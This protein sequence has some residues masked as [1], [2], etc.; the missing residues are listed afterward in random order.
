[1]NDLTTLSN[2]R[3]TILLAEIAA[4]LH[5]IGKLDPNFLFKQITDGD[6][7]NSELKQHNLYIDNYHYRRFASPN[8]KLFQNELYRK[9]TEKK[10]ATTPEIADTLS[11]LLDDQTINFCKKA[12]RFIN[13]FYY[14]NGPLYKVDTKE[15]LT[16]QAK[17]EE[18]FSKIIIGKNL[19]PW[20]L[21]DLL[22]LFWD[23]F[24]DQSSADG[25]DRTFALSPLMHPSQAANLPALLILSHTE[26]VIPEKKEGTILIKTS[27]KDLCYSSAFGYDHEKI[28]VFALQDARY[29]LIEN[30]LKVCEDPIGKRTELLDLASNN[31]SLGLGDTQWPI[32]EINLWDFSSSI[33]ALFKSGV[34]RG[35]LEG[36]I[37]SVGDMHWR[38]L[39]I[40]FDGLDFF[41]RAHHVTDLIGRREILETALDKVKEEL[42]KTYPLG[43][44]IYRDENGAVFVVPDLKEGDV[45]SLN[46]KNKK[47]LRYLLQDGFANAG[48]GED[49]PL[50]GE[51]RSHI[52]LGPTLRGKK[53]NLGEHLRKTPLSLESDPERMAGWWREEQAKNEKNKEICTVCGVRPVE[54]R[55]QNAQ[56]PGWVDTENAKDR[57]ICCVCLHRRGRRAEQW[58]K[59][60]AHTTIWAD[61]VVD[62]NSRFALLVGRFDLSQWLDGTLIATMQKPSSFAR[63]RRCWETTRKFWKDVEETTLPNL[64]DE[65]RPRFAITPGNKEELIS[66]DKKKGLGKYHTYELRVGGVDIGVV[67]DPIGKELILTEYLEDMARRLGLDKKYWQGEDDV[68]KEL[69]EWFEKHKTSAPWPLLEPSG[70]KQPAKQKCRI[71]S[72]KLHNDVSRYKPYIN[73]LTEP[74]LFMTLIPADKAMPV[75]SAIKEKY[76]REMSKVQDRLPLHLGV[77]IAQRRT[78][79]RAVMD[80]GRAMLDRDAGWQEWQ[81][82][83]SEPKSSSDAP[84]HL[85]NDAH[86]ANWQHIHLK[87]DARK[88]SMR[89]AKMMGDGEEPDQWHTHLLHH[90][91]NHNGELNDDVIASLIASKS[92][93]NP[94]KLKRDDKVYIS[95]STFDFEYLDTT[96]RRFEIAYDENG[97]RLG[98]PTRPYYLGKI[99]G[100]QKVWGIISDDTR[101]SSRQWMQVSELIERKRDAWGE[102]RGAVGGYSETFEQFI[103][104]TLHNIEWEKGQKLEKAEDW[105][106]LERAALHGVL[107]DVIDL[108][109]EALKEPEEA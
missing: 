78:P 2:E 60:H 19:E 6:F 63:V 85:Q 41:S 26:V 44:E 65:P 93:K 1:M 38:F 10:G 54:Y 57:H 43:N 33:A 108:Y 47:P 104:D 96:T 22:T 3:H 95:P 99:E 39:S 107:D 45:L 15:P 89:V 59:K 30:A 25:Y 92:W 109:H 86:F 21:S 70:Y 84:E 8:A 46:G 73:L 83:E 62:V 67:W 51:L 90:Q 28:D 23:N 61:E 81:V 66:K 24:F 50:D 31:L 53:L 77:V 34:A 105:T 68:V 103:S 94:D 49:A 55:P 87:K 35:V 76:E 29:K 88:I 42:E 36:E 52:S 106:L 20:L 98:R 91:S 32:N 12:A 80:A 72:E 100:L 18:K 9:I 5:N 74:A 17:L 11:E 37:P 40:R 7:A 75:V 71:S 56:M 14:E 16:E 13:R 58:L 102:P 69:R 64:W 82:V 97:Q 48:E 4:L 27:W 79:L 101:L